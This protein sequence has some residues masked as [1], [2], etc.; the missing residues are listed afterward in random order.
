M[1]A[2]IAVGQKKRVAEIPATRSFNGFAVGAEADRRV[3][4]LD[5]SRQRGARVARRPLLKLFALVH[6]GRISA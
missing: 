3:L 1:I 2:L 4:A 6:Y 5:E